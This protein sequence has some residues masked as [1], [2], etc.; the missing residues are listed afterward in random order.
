MPQIMYTLLL[1]ANMHGNEPT[2]RE[3]LV[4]LVKY[5]VLAKE[6][7]AKEEGP[8]TQDTLLH[9]AANILDTT[10]LWIVLNDKYTLSFGNPT[11]EH[12]TRCCQ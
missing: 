11:R 3:L 6:Y 2:G 4:H 5:I 9:R 10:D 12:N 8:T 1:T 7:L